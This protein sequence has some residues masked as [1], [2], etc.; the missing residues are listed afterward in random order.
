MRIHA[1]YHAGALGPTSIPEDIAPD[2]APEDEEAKL[3]YFTLP[4]ALNYQRDSARLWTAALR[5]YEDPT[6]AWVFDLQR[7]ATAPEGG[8]REALLRHRLAIQPTRHVANWDTIAKSAW[9]RWGGLMGLVEASERDFL[10]LR[11]LV[12]VV[13]KR[14]FPYLSGPKLFNYWAYTLVTRC[15]IDLANADEIDIAV[16]TH[17]TKASVR[18]GLISE[19]QAESLGRDD[20]AARWRAALR[21]SDLRPVD[22]NVPLWKWSRAG[23]PELD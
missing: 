12:R 21:G 10:N 2:F 3:C 13:H 19:A 4:M 23:F 14:E 18:L 17:V 16:D 5:T 1:A 9:E 6:L 22:L 15:A 8:L 7:V 20:V 11:R